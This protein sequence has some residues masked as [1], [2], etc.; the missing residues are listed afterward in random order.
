MNIFSQLL[1][2]HDLSSEA[3]T[4]ARSRVVAFEEEQYKKTIARLKNHSPASN[5]NVPIN[6]QYRIQRVVNTLHVVRKY[7]SASVHEIERWIEDNLCMF[8]AAGHY[9][10]FINKTFY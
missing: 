2:Y 5:I 10:S 3:K 4:V 1:H 9:Y 7:Q 8:D 6:D